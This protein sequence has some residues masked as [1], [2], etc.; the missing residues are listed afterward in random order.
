MKKFYATLFTTIFFTFT[1]LAIANDDA[2]K[3][4]D[5]QDKLPVDPAI[6][7][8]Q[9]DNGLTYYIKKNVKPEKRAELRLAVNVGSVLE[10]EDQLGLAHFVEHMAFNGTEHFKKHE[11]VD[12]FESIG[13][14]FGPEVNAYTS[15]DETVYMLHIPTDSTEIIE[16]SF[17]VLRDWS[18]GLLFEDEEIEK[19]RGVVIEEWRLGRGA[20]ARIRDKQFPIILHGSHYAERLPIGK[21]EILDTFTYEIPKRFYKDWYRPDLMAVIAVGDFDLEY[22]KKLIHD[23]FADIPAAKDGRERK[24]YPIPGHDETLFAI[25]SDSELPRSTVGIYYKLPLQDEETVKDYRHRVVERVYNE[26]FNQR[27]AELAKQEDPPFMGAFSGKGQFIRTSEFYILQ[28]AV[29]DNGIPRGLETLLTEAKRVKEHGFTATELEREKK[30]VLR[31]MEQ[32]YK[33][34]D[35]TQSSAFAAEYIRSFLYD[36]PIPGIEYEYEIYKQFVPGITLE[37]VNAL[38]GEWISDK[39]RVISADCPEKEG[40]NIPS[41]QELSAVLDKVTQTTVEPYVDDVLEAP[42][43]EEL[44]EPSPVLFEKYHKELD[45]TEWKMRNGMRV[46]LKPTD[47]KND[48]ILF[49]ATSPGGHSLV[50]DSN[51]TAAQTAAN[52]VIESGVGEFTQIQ[53]NK[54][55]ADKVVRVSPYISNLTEGFTGNVSP[56]DLETLF[57]LIYLYFTQPR[58]DSTVFASVKSRMEGW[59]QN[60]SASPEAAFFDTITAVI[61]QNHPRFK[62]WT[63]ET[64]QDMNL[65]KSMAIYQ[66]RFADASDFL[67]FFVGNFQVDKMKPL[68]EQYLGGLPAIRRKETWADITYRYPQGIVKKSVNKG[69]EPKSLNA[70]V[71]TGPFE[72]NRLNRFHGDAMLSVLRIKLRERV[73]EDLGGTYG[74]RVSGSYPHYPIQRYRIDIQFGCNPDRVEELTKEVYTQIDSMINYGITEDYLKKVK[75]TELRDYERNSKENNFWV[76]NLEFKYFHGEDPNDILDYPRMV[77]SLTLAD[78]QNAAKKYLNKDNYV[79][80]VLYPEKQE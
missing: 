78:I 39:S 7:K 21:K 60:R 73:R 61:T 46:I 18:K 51:L 52:L 57:Q 62:P 19:E 68:V 75:E 43:V 8:G 4:I 40:I 3:E 29:R 14:K 33:E 32:V 15:F 42:L 41:E 23:N 38:A 79:R 70:I 11:L 71:F 27:L 54:E 63:V 13:M 30:A 77:E 55:L 26:M 67:C 2:K 66:D 25:A 64:F 31:S 12:Y 58:E 72:W 5:L 1:L 53:L 47:Y 65:A 20:F 76:N 37:E 10:D 45:V 59:Y 36:E 28:A 24:Y 22:I 9:L 50:P 16:K 69:A 49:S 80:V 35:K 44:P 48:E 17:L 6:I 34:R 74:V 56:E